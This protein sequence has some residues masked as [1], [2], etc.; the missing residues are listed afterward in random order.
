LHG[1]SEVGRGREARKTRLKADAV[2]DE[3]QRGISIEQRR[4]EVYIK[5]GSWGDNVGQEVGAYMANT[6][7]GEKTKPRWVRPL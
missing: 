4:E 1:R 7:L 3:C 6:Y 2:K 5:E